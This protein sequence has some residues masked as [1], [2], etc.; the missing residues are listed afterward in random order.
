M[1]LKRLDY[2]YKQYIKEPSQFY[3]INPE[4]KNFYIWHIL[5]LPPSNTIF[6]GGIFKCI[7]NFSKDYPNKAPEFKFITELPHP[8]IY[9]DGKVCISILH[10]GVDHYESED[11]SERWNPS[12][13][14]NS[15]IMSI[16]SILIAPNLDS[17]ANVDSYKLYR[18]NYNEYKKIIYRLIKNNQ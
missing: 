5:I 15:I 8:N 6:E 3:T 10:D 2:E 1:A 17:I 4:S 16:I 11:I 14:V 12:H 7:I 18:D 13:S 9:Q